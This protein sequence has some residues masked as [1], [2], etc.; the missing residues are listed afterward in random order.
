LKKTEGEP[1]LDINNYYNYGGLLKAFCLSADLTGL[2][3]AN[4]RLYIPEDTVKA[5][6]RF[7]LPER[8]IVFHARSI[9]SERNWNDEKWAELLELLRN[10]LELFTVEIGLSAVL[11]SDSP[12]YLSLSGR[13][14]L[15]ELAEV[16]RRATLFIGVDSGPAHLANAARTPG[17]VLLGSYRSFP[18]YYPYSGGYADGSLAK[19]IHADGPASGLSVER[20][21]D[22]VASSTADTRGT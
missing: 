18:R 16:I 11:P 20:V 14:N 17:V 3:D 22:A 9:E 1:G 4:P 21:F 15:L 6:D 2:E 12:R 7:N 5:V 10:D 19:L 13:T 8:F